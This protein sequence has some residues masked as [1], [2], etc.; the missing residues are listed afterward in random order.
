MT[1]RRVKQV[2]LMLLLVIAGYI[3]WGNL[4]LLFPTTVPVD[5]QA[6]GDTLGASRALLPD[7]VV[8]REPRVNPFLHAIAGPPDQSHER[9]TQPAGPVAFPRSLQLAGVLCL[10][11]SSQAVLQLDPQ[12]TK[13]FSL[14]EHFG[15]WTLIEVTDETAVFGADK[16]RDTLHLVGTVPGDRQ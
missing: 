11:K 1:T 8:Y 6:P 2:L 4:A 5:T 12:T 13:T 7:P 15:E 10:G 16:A 14:G 9:T 3:W